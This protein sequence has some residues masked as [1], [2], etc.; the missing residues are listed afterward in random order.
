MDFNDG[1]LLGYGRAQSGVK[2]WERAAQK[3]RSQLDDVDA[4]T[5]EQWVQRRAWLEVVR[6]MVDEIRESNPSSP[7]TNRDYINELFSS[8]CDEMRDQL[9]SGVE[10]ER[11]IVTPR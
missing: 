9:Q 1:L 6:V 8:M 7:L 11:V 10:P 3:L 2:V 5:A 4:T